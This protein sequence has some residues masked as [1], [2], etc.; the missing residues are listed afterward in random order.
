MLQGTRTRGHHYFQQKC[1]VRIKENETA[2][3]A[4]A[5][6]TVV[7]EKTASSYLFLL[8]FILHDTNSVSVTNYLSFMVLMATRCDFPRERFQGETQSWDIEIT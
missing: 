6:G 8:R 5:S 3:D 2:D 4:H 1:S 7:T